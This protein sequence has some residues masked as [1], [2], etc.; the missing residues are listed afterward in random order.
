[1]QQNHL[2]Q[3]IERLPYP[4][5]FPGDIFIRP[6]PCD[7][8]GRYLK[9]QKKKINLDGIGEYEIWKLIGVISKYQEQ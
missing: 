6:I 1:M 2:D 9:F 7:S 5:I 3:I 8:Q 4:G